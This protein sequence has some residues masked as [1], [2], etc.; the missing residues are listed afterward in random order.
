LRT[1]EEKRMKEKLWTVIGGIG[2]IILFA[3]ASAMD[4]ETMSLPV[5]MVFVGL[6]LSVAAARNLELDE[7]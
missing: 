7:K 6:G 2:M 5:L 3:G 1:K 4:S